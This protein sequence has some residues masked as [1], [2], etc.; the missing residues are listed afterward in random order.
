MQAEKAHGMN[1]STVAS[2]A[3]SGQLLTEIANAMV[4]LHKEQFGRG[5]TR[6]RASFAGPDVLI[7]V[8]DDVLLPAERALVEMGQQERVRESRLFM[9]VATRDR[10]AARV[11]SIVGRQVLSFVSASDPDRD[12]VYEICEFVPV[13]GSRG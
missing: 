7:C 4:A 12:V 6:A 8:L 2:S 9:Q 5:P 13:D 1:D 10:F 3:N 11:E